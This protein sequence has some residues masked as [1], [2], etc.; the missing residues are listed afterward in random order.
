VAILAERASISRTTLGKIE[1]GD[2]GVSMG[3]YATVLFVLGLLDRLEELAAPENDPTGLALED[4]RLPQRIRLPRR[5]DPTSPP[6]DD[7]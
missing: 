2:P 3:A 1:K 6:E 7:R 4:E 5:K